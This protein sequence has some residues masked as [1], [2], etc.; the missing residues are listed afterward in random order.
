LIIGDNSV[1]CKGESDKFPERGCVSP[2]SCRLPKFCNY[3]QHFPLQ[4][5]D[6]TTSKTSSYSTVATMSKTKRGRVKRTTGRKKGKGMRAAGKKFDASKGAFPH[7]LST[8]EPTR[9]AKLTSHFSA[10]CGKHRIQSI[11]YVPR[12]PERYGHTRVR[13]VRRV[14]PF[15]RTVWAPINYR[16]GLSISNR[17]RLIDR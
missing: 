2:T 5:R 15:S 12:C 7:H 11:R 6:V 16:S 4:S 13:G 3:Q 10:S 1:L 14:R 9:K 8:P 17:Y